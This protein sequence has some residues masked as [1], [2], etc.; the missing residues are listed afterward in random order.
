LPVSLCDVI[1][2]IPSSDAG[3]NLTI[4]GLSVD[5]D[6]NNNLCIKA[7]NLLQQQFSLPGIDA[8][9]LKNVPLGAGL[10]GGSADGAF[11]LKLLNKLFE[12]NISNEEMK[13]F[14]AI[15]GSDCPFFIDNAHSFVGGRGEFLEPLDSGLSGKKLV[16]VHPGIHISTA[17]AYAH[18]KPKAAPVNLRNISFN[19]GREWTALVR[20]DFESYM[21]KNYPVIGDIKTSLCNAG[22]FYSSM[23]GSGSAVYGIFEGESTVPD[24]GPSYYVA[25]C[26]I[27]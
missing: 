10:G 12:L 1:E 4:K 21:L 7:Y 16:I 15:L 13:R 6:L 19:D 24:F 22:A 2:A 17:E 9:L 14:A 18:M 27:M 11:M 26:E 3:C 8:C 23:S 5:G 20:N 25:Q